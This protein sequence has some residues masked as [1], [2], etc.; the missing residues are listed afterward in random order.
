MTDY[1]IQEFAEALNQ[2][3]YLLDE[4]DSSIQISP[5]NDSD[6][7][8]HL[9]LLTKEAIEVMLARHI[10]TTEDLAKA[11]TTISQALEKIDPDASAPESE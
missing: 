8:A 9:S 1:S 3:L 11:V 5:P 2:L 6:S 4:L 10:Y 7:E